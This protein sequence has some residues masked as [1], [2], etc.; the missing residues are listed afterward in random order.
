MSTKQERLSVF[1]ETMKA[2]LSHE[3][4]IGRN[5]ERQIDG[6]EEMMSTTKFYTKRVEIDTSK[7]TKSHTEQISIR[8]M[9]SLEAAKELI[10]QG[11]RPA[12]LNMASFSTPGGGVERGSQAQEEIICRRTNLLMSLYQFHKNG[13]NYGIQQSQDQ[14][15]L[16]FPFGAVYTPQVA[17]FR[18]TDARR[19]EFLDEP[20]YV[21]IITL[22]SLKRPKLTSDG[23]LSKRDASI[24]KSKVEQILSIA[25]ENGNDSVVLGA[26]GCGA[27][28]NPPRHVAEIF[29]DVLVNNPTFKNTFQEIIFAILEDASSFKEHNKE[30]NIQPFIDVFGETLIIK[31]ENN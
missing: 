2:A 28:A 9:D 12:V 7:V 17:V 22:P 30:G 21:D 20:W 14:Y 23:M 15:P 29:H 13:D 10:N 26:F 4:P 1:K 6:T 16:S 25:I 5:K 11:F 8:N 18:D 24:I 19:Y 3:Y 27:Y 31:N